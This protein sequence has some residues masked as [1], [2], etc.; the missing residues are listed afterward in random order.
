MA[1][2]LLSFLVAVDDAL[3]RLTNRMTFTIL[4]LQMKHNTGRTAIQKHKETRVV[5]I[6]SLALLIVF[7]SRA[8]PLQ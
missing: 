3:H 5:L 1:H 7:V 2:G 4:C 8:S 6:L